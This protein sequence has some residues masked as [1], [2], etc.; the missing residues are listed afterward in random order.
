M[1]T[2]NTIVAR[3]HWR[4][5]GVT[6]VTN[7]QYHQISIFRHI[8]R[9]LWSLVVTA[10]LLSVSIPLMA[11]KSVSPSA[12]DFQERD[13]L[14]PSN[15]Q[16]AQGRR[17]AESA[18][19]GCHGLDGISLDANQ[20]HLAGQR[21]IYLY[22]ELQAY[23]NGERSDEVMQA[24]VEFLNN[25]ALLN[26]AIF[27]SSLTLTNDRNVSNTKPEQ[28]ETDGYS[29]LEAGAEAAANCGGCHGATGNSSI[30]GS[31]NLTAQH[32]DYFLTATKAYQDGTRP[33]AMMNMLVATLDEKTIENL[34]LY[35]ALQE[36][37]RATAPSIGDVSAGQAAAEACTICH[38]AVGNT[39]T[40]NTPT[41]A[42]QDATYLSSATLA[43]QNG[44]RDHEDMTNA[45][46]DLDKI[47]IDNLSA[48]YSEQKPIQR[49]VRKP[50][51]NADWVER[52][53]RCHG[54]NGNSADPRQPALAG[55]NEKYLL[56]VL[57]EY[58]TGKRKISTM[59]AMS[60]VLSEAN[61]KWLAAHY[62]AQEPRSA[63][64]IIVPCNDSETD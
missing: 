23:Q 19:A 45:V 33:H 9:C 37:N 62:A 56:R 55:Q 27:Y 30:P 31:P 3:I 35:Y 46:S 16:I 41:L 50:L 58:A 52:C 12:L 25:D 2:G 54:I 20:P 32:P 38:G 57:G 49:Q 44:Q 61:I 5:F 6:A 59:H 4:V 24:A 22:R 53:D 40:A 10:L 43:Y 42:G 64:Y 15:Q 34:G 8:N 18:C 28:S 26:L 11:Q 13:S 21:T 17:V 63:T 48:F 36:P 29:P 51:S 60:E 14:N 47:M 39:A 1:T 7:R